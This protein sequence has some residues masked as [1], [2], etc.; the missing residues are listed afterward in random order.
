MPQSA[1]SAASPASTWI[2]GKTVVITGATSGIGRAAAIELARRGATMNVVARDPAK[3]A[4]LTDEIAQTTSAPPVRTFLADLARLDQV[5]SVASEM[6]ATL[7]PVHVLVN[8]AGVAARHAR[9][10]DDGWDEM[11]AAN[12]LGPWLLTQLLLERIK[13]AAPSRIVVTGSE[14]H[15]LTGH[16]DPEHFEDLGVYSGFSAQ[17]AYGRT[18][19]LDIL[20]A[21]ELARR[22]PDWG[23]TVSS[24]CPGLV[25][26]GLVRDVRGADR[27]GGLLSATPLIRTPEQG[28]RMLIHLAADEEAAKDH[29]RFRSSTPGASLLPI[30]GPRRQPAV[31]R[32]V[33]ERTSQLLG[34]E[35]PA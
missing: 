13:A 9:R 24:F 6:L 15:R 17:L 26:T 20:F 5:R 30:A 7:G 10:T 21:D 33:Y 18:K 3:A 32:R 1:S 28:A 19:L 31:A 34:V 35:Q 22:I 27:I 12:Y 16:F 23:V 4:A 14:A 25:N 11:L 2:S 29:G 8:N